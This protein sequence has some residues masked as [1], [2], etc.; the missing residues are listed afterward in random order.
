MPDPTPTPTFEPALDGNEAATV[1]LQAFGHALIDWWYLWLLML[2]VG[3]GLAMLAGWAR[4]F[5]ERHAPTRSTRRRR[6]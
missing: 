3:I 4:R 5:E 6:R 2:A 1:I